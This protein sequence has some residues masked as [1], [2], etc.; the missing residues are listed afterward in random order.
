MIE[1][2]IGTHETV[3]HKSDTH[4]RLYVNDEC[5]HYPPHWHN[6]MEILCPL[7]GTYTAICPKETYLLRPRDILFIGAGTIHDLPA[8]SEGVRII[9]Q[10]SWSPLREINGMETAL[11]RLSPCCLITPE[12]SPSIHREV[13]RRLLEI[14]DFYLQSPLLTEASIYAR[15]LE[16]ITLVS[17]DRKAIP[18][19]SEDA[20]RTRLLQHRE[21]MQKICDYLSD[22]CSENLT[23]DDAA[24]QAGFSKY[25]FE[26]LFRDYTDMSFY[27]YLIAKRISFA[28]QLLMDPQMP[29]TEI[30]F[31]SGFAS[32]AAFSKAFRQAKGFTP[33]QF[34]RL[35]TGQSW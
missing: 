13:H 3:H 5:E 25:Y 26:R 7:E 16:M 6:D 32:G 33:S 24:A 35:Q 17:R 29:I 4:V 30:A 23:L 28:E 1:T 15:A 18:E 14:R 19:L 27:Q 9:F 21:A 8:A 34:R 22:H 20:S 12:N 11:S 10:I 2:L 31:R